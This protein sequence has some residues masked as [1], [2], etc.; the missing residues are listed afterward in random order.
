VL[1]A[2]SLGDGAALARLQDFVVARGASRS[3]S[4]LSHLEV[5]S[6]RWGRAAGI[7]AGV[8][9]VCARS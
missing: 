3:N 6:R 2:Y 5:G 1:R 4:Y 9:V 7:A 8:A